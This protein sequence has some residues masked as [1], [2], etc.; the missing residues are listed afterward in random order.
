V[1]DEAQLGCWLLGS[2]FGAGWLAGYGWALYRA[3]GW[4]DRMRAWAAKVAE[5]HETREEV[6]GS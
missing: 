1:S 3:V 5:Q 4:V 2:A 6:S